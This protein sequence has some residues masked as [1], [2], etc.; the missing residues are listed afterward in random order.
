MKSKKPFYT[1]FDECE[2]GYPLI[3]VCHNVD[4]TCFHKDKIKMIYGATVQSR[5][6]YTFDLKYAEMRYNILLDIESSY[7]NDI[8]R[9]KKLQ[10]WITQY[11]NTLGLFLYYNL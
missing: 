6:Y 10:P 2:W 1:S 3:V 7:K 9:N 8:K 4:T 5:M 11:T